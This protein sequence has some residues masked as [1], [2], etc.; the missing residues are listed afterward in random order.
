MDTAPE[1]LL[2][3]FPLATGW[4]AVAVPPGTGD[5]TLAGLDDALLPF[6]AP[7]TAATALIAA[8]DSMGARAR[9]LDAEDWWFRCRFDWSPAAGEAEHVL[10]LEAMTRA[11][12]DAAAALCVRA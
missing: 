5:P 9:D 8:G 10:Q 11:W 6:T 4:A 2:E 12:D 1:P 7:G 3:R